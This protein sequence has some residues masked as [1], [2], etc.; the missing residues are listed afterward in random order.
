[1]VGHVD[2]SVSVDFVSWKSSSALFDRLENWAFC[3]AR[4]FGVTESNGNITFD[5]PTIAWISRSSFK[6]APFRYFKAAHL[7]IV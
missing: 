6:R 3:E 1:L 4:A 2:R 5:Q 7:F